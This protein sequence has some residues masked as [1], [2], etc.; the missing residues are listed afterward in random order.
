MGRLTQYRHYDIRTGGRMN[1]SQKALSQFIAFA[2]KHAP[3]KVDEITSAIT[4]IK[5]L[6][7]KET[8]IKVIDKKFG[9]GIFGK[10]ICGNKIS[11][12]DRCCNNCGQRIDWSE[13]ELL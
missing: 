11:D 4:E 13:D 3:N 8:P 2:N 5:R 12:V 1:E 10:C 6:I 9:I 7:D